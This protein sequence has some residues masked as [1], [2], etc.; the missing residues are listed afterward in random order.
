MSTKRVRFAD[1]QEGPAV[2][3][4]GEPVVTGS[5]QSRSQSLSS[6]QSQSSSQS[7]SQSNS[8]NVSQDV[9]DVLASQQAAPGVDGYQLLVDMTLE[10][11]AK[12]R[13]GIYRDMRTRRDTRGRR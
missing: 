11:H 13:N 7:R 3:V 6:S 9:D 8:I 5:S 2:S 1:V 12:L 10:L 4:A